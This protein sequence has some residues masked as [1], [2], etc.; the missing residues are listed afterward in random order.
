MYCCAIQTLFRSLFSIIALCTAHFTPLPVLVVLAGLRNSV[1]KP[2]LSKD[3]RRPT[4]NQNNLCAFSNMI[5]APQPFT[6]SALGVLASLALA[7]CCPAAEPADLVLRG[8]KIVTLDVGQPE[9]EA[10]AIRGQRIVAVGS[11]EAIREHIGQQTKIIELDGRM[12]MPGFIEGHVHFLSLGDSKRKL[13]LA[14]ARSWEEIIDLVAKTAR[15][16]PA[17]QWIVGRGWHQGKW[18]RPPEPSVQGYPTHDALSRLTPNHPVLLTHGTGHMAFANA[19]AME[20]AGISS[21]SPQ[22]A[23]GEILRDAAGKPTGAFRENAAGPVR[24][25]YDRSLR[26]R[27]PDQVRSD[28]VEAARLAAAECLAHGVTSF[29]DAGTSL[30]DADALKALAE[31][32]KLPVRLWVMLNEGNDRLAPNLARYR[33]IGAGDGYFTVRAIKRMADGALGTHGAWLLAPYDDLPGSSG[34]NT[35]PLEAL[36]RTAELALEHKYQLCVHAIGDRANREVLDVFE[37]VFAKRNVKGADVR[38]RIEHAQHIDPADIPRF[39]QLGVIA[40][41]QG[42]HCT[43]DAPFVIARLGERRAKTGAY[44]WRS[45]LDSGATVINGTDVPVELVDPIASFHSS[46]T[47]KLASGVAFFPE[48]AMTRAEALRSYTRDAAYAAFEDD[49]KGTLAIGKLADIVVL[50]SDLRTVPE[51][52]VLKTRVAYTIVCGKVVYE[53]R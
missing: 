25:A 6:C 51:D 45:L 38:W 50:T 2:F 3:F 9:A 31:E 5:F 30:A 43:S 52:E 34:H 41:M 4:G 49:T 26:D 27:T 37:R 11:S 16:T 44:A 42:V 24:R 21:A 46:V 10:L 18:T 36:E 1:H 8:G 13:E 28:L 12:A 48:Q 17:G 29:H 15:T 22:I 23:G 20:L 32:G 7:W 35:L 19:K 39:G 33:T 47:R 40:S 53:S 14:S